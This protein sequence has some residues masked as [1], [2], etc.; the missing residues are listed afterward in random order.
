MGGEEMSGKATEGEKMR[1]VIF[2]RTDFGPSNISLPKNCTCWTNDDV[3]K[4]D[5]STHSVLYDIVSNTFHP[6]MV[7][8]DTWCSSGSS[9][10][11]APS[12]L[13]PNNRVIVVSGRGVFTYEF[14]PR[15][16]SLPSSFYLSLLRGTIDNS[17]ENNLYLFLHLLPGSNLFIFANKRS[18]SFD[19]MNN[20][21]V[22]EFYTCRRLKLTDLNLVWSMETMS[23]PRVMPD[24]LLLPISDV[25]FI[26]GANHS[27]VDSNDAKH[28][29]F[30]QV[31]YSPD[32]EPTWRFTILNSLNIPMMYQSSA[33]LLPNGNILVGGSN[34]HEKCNFTLDPYPT[35]LREISVS[36][37]TPSSTT[38]SFSMNQR[39][40]VLNV[41][42]IER[43]FMTTYQIVVNGPLLRRW[44]YLGII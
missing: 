17:E 2:Y 31:L 39:M 15:K 3:E 43:A 34:P 10:N 6:L 35:N 26:N 44:H 18:I 38:Y 22:N 11:M 9:I 23:M 12:Q 14:Y 36:F 21:V 30:N 42:N 24:M 32:E 5:C 28:S 20:K 19:Y 4:Q 29:N 1:A 8:T 27:T 25:V 13:L 37:V 7:Q 16:D 33:L 41:F 40:V